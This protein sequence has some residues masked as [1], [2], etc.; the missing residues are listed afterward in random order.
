MRNLRAISICAGACLLMLALVALFPSGSF[1]A[2]DAGGEMPAFGMTLALE[3]GAL[4][5]RD[6]VPDGP[7]YRAGVRSG[8]TFITIDGVALK[9]AT[10]AQVQARLTAPRSDAVTLMVRRRSGGN[11]ELR[12]KRPAPNAA[13]T[14]AAAALRSSGAL[15]EGQEAGIPGPQSTGRSD[16]ISRGTVNVG[17][18]L[19]DFTLPRLGGGEVT[20]SDYAG[21][22]ILLDF[23]AT[24]C[25][26]CRAAAP[27]LAVITTR[28]GDAIQII[29][30]NMDDQPGLAIQYAQGAGLTYPHA[31]SKG[32]RDPVVREYG[33]HRTGIPFNVLFD[34]D[35]RVAA[36]DL[37]GQPLADALE[38][39]LRR[40]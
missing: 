32:W 36:M 10:F 11:Q 14:A 28:F 4:V 18:E 5:V 20:L 6:L 2:A 1:V 38:L 37:H 15:D 39:L 22:P 27:G 33:I 25:G 9:G 8:D 17:D 7:A 30:V 13:L 16:V 31:F 40:E 23:W 24:W 26:P 35:G 3:D 21:K 19:I 29:G 34:A 12:L